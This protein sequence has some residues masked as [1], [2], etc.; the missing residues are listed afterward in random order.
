MACTALRNIRSRFFARYRLQRH[1]LIP[2]VDTG[3]S[4]WHKI[5]RIVIF[6]LAVQFLHMFPVKVKIPSSHSS[7]IKPVCL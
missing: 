5:V 7:D 3:E 4:G 1:T 2:Q 6:P